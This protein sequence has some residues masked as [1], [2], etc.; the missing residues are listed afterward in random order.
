MTVDK[1]VATVIA[2]Y[3][4]AADVPF[5]FAYPGDPIIDFMEASRGLGLDVVLARREGTAA[6]MAEGYAM[7]T[8]KLGVVLSTLGPGSSNMVNGVA[9]ANWDRVPLLAISGQIDTAR[10]Q[11]FTHQVIDH[12]LLYSPIT[13]WA[14]RVESGAVGTIMRKA[15]ST[16]TSERPGAVH[17]TIAED[18]FKATA[19]DAAVRMPPMGS[20]VSG[21][22]VSRAPGSSADPNKILSNAKRPIILAGISAQRGNATAELIALAENTG[23]PVVTSPMSKGV[24]PE[25]HPLFA[26]VIDMACQQVMWDFL[27][28]ADLIISVGFDAVELIKPWTVTAPVLHID[29]TPNSDQIYYSECEVVGDIPLMLNWLNSEWK[30]GQKWSEGDVSSHRNALREAY[31]SGRVQGKLNPTD[32]VDVVRAAMPRNTLGTSD[33]GSHKMLIGQGWT[34]HDPRGLLMTNGLSSM[35]FGVPTAI[36]AAMA[37]PSRPVVA[38]VGDGG[39]AMTATEMRLA[40]ARNLPLVV[41]VFADGSL[42][43]IELKQMAR[44]FQ[45]TATRI[46]DSDLVAMAE[47]MHCDGARATSIKE[48]EQVLSSVGSIT[49]PL[50]IEAK[51]D[52]SQYQAQ[53]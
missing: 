11:Y 48:L 9:C 3:V 46:E 27:G 37:D 23:I 8:G 14:G 2:E 6:F 4:K 41:V 33:V 36:A 17:L 28:S 50:V 25:E 49:R 7:A 13:K 19:K 12:K 24:F 45:S 5:V 16:A 34:T 30:G 10:E 39:F 26:G 32:V 18:T 20:S 31:Y 53:F 21:I 52:P 1:S 43:R 35:G 15:I 51:V 22:K 44:G 38:L 40:S 29:S 42:N 47:A